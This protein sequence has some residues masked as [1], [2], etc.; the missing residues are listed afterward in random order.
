MAE[1]RK[2]A[3][4]EF[5]QAASI[6]A[7]GLITFANRSISSLLS[8]RTIGEAH[9]QDS[10]K[11][12][13]PMSLSRLKKA[14]AQMDSKYLRD[15]WETKDGYFVSAKIDGRNNSNGIYLE[16]T[17]GIYSSTLEKKLTIEFPEDRT[18]PNGKRVYLRVDLQ[19]LHDYHVTVCE[20]KGCEKAD[21]IWIK[22][23]FEV[24]DKGVNMFATFADDKPK[25][26][27]SS[28]LKVGYPIVGLVYDK[29]QNG[30]S[31]EGVYFRIENGEKIARK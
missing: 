3:R 5:I 9:A 20:G 12:L 26:N 17:A 13:A 21:K 2:L 16:V 30:A 11:N 29:I 8:G 27:D 6:G 23:M 10:V 15:F 22:V 24:L 25:P 1:P 18:K 31:P 4:R 28:D 7:V 19:K 14:D